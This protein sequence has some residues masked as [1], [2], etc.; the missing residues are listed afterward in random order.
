MSAVLTVSLD[1]YLDTQRLSFGSPPGSEITMPQVPS[2]DE[3]YPVFSP[4]PGV[5]PAGIC[6][7]LLFNNSLCF[8]PDFFNTGL[9]GGKHSISSGSAGFDTNK[10]LTA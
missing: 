10:Y 1:G 3:S 6:L 9:T 5:R 4:V 2:S 7:F 8:L